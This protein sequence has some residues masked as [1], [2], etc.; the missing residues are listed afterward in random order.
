MHYELR[1]SLRPS[2]NHLL[3]KNGSRLMSKLNLI[4]YLQTRANYFSPTLEKNDVFLVPF[5]Y[6]FFLSFSSFDPIQ[7]DDVSNFLLSSEPYTN[8][9]LSAATLCS[10][11]LL[12]NQNLLQ[13]GRLFVLCM[14]ILLY[15]L[16]SFINQFWK[17]TYNVHTC[18]WGNIYMFIW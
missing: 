6:L 12:A 2:E 10:T 17:C 5:A 4:F 18:I 11:S 3:R 13:L 16:N 15:H 1:P 7:Y 9:P 8:F 14:H